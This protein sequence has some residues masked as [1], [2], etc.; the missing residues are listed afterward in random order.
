LSRAA[1]SV[2]I[3][4]MST[5]QFGALLL[6]EKDGKVSASFPMLD[7]SALPQ[8]DVTVDV[9]CSTL[10]Y[11][12]G[13][14]LNGLG[15]LVRKY[16]HV[17]GIDFA[18]TVSASQSSTYKPGDKV[19]LTGW[20]VGELHWGGYAQK[21]R[22]KSEWLVPMPAGLTPQRAMAI[23]T[24]GFTA[25]LCV[26]DLE[27]HGLKRDG[28]EVLVTGAAGGVG[29]V[30]VAILA[31]LGYTVAAST[32]RADQADYLKSLGASVVVPRAELTVEKPKPLASERWNHAIDTVGGLVLS[33]LLAGLKYGAA[34][35]ACGNAGGIDLNTTVLPFILRGAKLIGIDSVMRSFADRRAA[36]DRLVRDLPM[37][38]LDAMMTTATLRDLPALGAKILK[39][40]MR[41]RTVIDVARGI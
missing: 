28:G 29:S 22:V 39:G 38:K 27:A 9:T 31:K 11:K 20:R 25:M 3:A 10:N 2:K 30:A 35:A 17:P 14:I 1:Q 8:G 26:L 15:R 23:G 24:A 32:G 19:I 4:D 7:E 16:P 12:D 6:E 41:G 21:A 37:D 34:V 33:N 18:G 40:Q 13:L 5:N 36:W